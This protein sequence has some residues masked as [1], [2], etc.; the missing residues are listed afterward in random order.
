MADLLGGGLV[1]LQVLV[2]KPLDGHEPHPR[3]GLYSISLRYYL[4]NYFTYVGGEESYPV[5]PSSTILVFSDIRDT[6]SVAQQGVFHTYTTE[7]VD[8]MLSQTKGIFKAI[9]F[10][11]IE[12]WNGPLNYFLSLM[13]NRSLSLTFKRSTKVS[14]W[15]NP[16]HSSLMFSDT[17]LKKLSI[18]CSIVLSPAKL[19]TLLHCVARMTN[20]ESLNL[21]VGIANPRAHDPIRAS[22]IIATSLKQFTALREFTLLGCTFGT[23]R[24]GENL[25]DLLWCAVN[26]TACATVSLRSTDEYDGSCGPRYHLN[27][28]SLQDVVC[29]PTSWQLR[30]LH[31][32][33]VHILP[34]VRGNVRQCNNLQTLDL[35]HAFRLHSD[36]TTSLRGEDQFFKTI[37][38][39]LLLLFPSLVYCRMDC[40]KIRVL[41]PFVEYLKDP[42]CSLREL[43]L[44]HNYLGGD[45][46]ELV[47]KNMHSWKRLKILNLRGN[48]FEAD[49][50]SNGVRSRYTTALWKC[51]FHDFF[52]LDRHRDE[53][54]SPYN[55][56]TSL[57][58]L[59]QFRSTLTTIR[60]QY[61]DLRI[62]GGLWHFLLAAVNKM[63]VGRDPIV[64]TRRQ[65]EAH[66]HLGSFRA[67]CRRSIYADRASVIFWILSVPMMQESL[68]D[69]TPVQSRPVKRQR[70]CIPKL[71]N[72]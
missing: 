11:N 36:L 38:R 60:N 30:N 41:D 23:L 20:L 64:G 16:L 66:R 25:H 63:E 4:Q 56:L 65:F 24:L 28:A 53:L 19:A 32:R 8:S 45:A 71:E 14:D 54:R 2:D 37:T 3:H 33:G 7:E 67:S 48:P 27:F 59:H 31:L 47:L 39:D 46:I 68:M 9:K 70:L 21:G 34:N 22:S 62:P 50:L 58:S 43:S 44:A 57:L 5:S 52:F 26:Q 40:S 29:G 72:K 18:Q 13:Q 49:L 51:S 6:C 55:L 61:E 10:R 69:K 42:M 15:I 35:S 12:T 17:P 1:K